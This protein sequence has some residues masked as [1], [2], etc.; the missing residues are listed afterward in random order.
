MLQSMIDSVR[1]AGR[2]LATGGPLAIALAAASSVGTRD[3]LATPPE[4]PPTERVVSLHVAGDPYVVVMSDADAPISPERAAAA[5]RKRGA[6]AVRHP[7]RACTRVRVTVVSPD[8]RVE[9]R[10]VSQRLRQ[11]IATD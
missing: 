8:G 4:V 3:A 11:P 6:T 2:A 5:R 10:V 1:R 9:T 7:L